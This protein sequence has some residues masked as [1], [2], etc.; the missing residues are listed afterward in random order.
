MAS[1]RG[2][3]SLRNL[4]TMRSQTLCSSQVEEMEKVRSHTAETHNKGDNC[5]I[6]LNSD[7]NVPD[8]DWEIP[9]L[10]PGCHH[11]D[12]CDRLIEITSEHHLEQIQREPTRLNNIL[13]LL[14]T[15][16]SVL[17]K[18]VSI[19]PGLSDHSTVLVDTYL[20][21][22]HNI[23]L[24][25]KSTNGHVLTGTRW[26]KRW[27]WVF[28]EQYFNTAPTQSVYQKSLRHLLSTLVSKHVP[29]KVS[30]SRRNISGWC[31]PYTEYAG[32]SRGHT[33]KPRRSAHHIAGGNFAH[34][35]DAPQQLLGQQEWTT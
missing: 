34:T 21:I 33:T 7:F 35:N 4:S 12:M 14:F 1:G 32:R 10:K 2:K 28:R 26:E 16:K 6:L 11:K 3:L 8:K 13:D 23:K 19:M 30:S 15:N 17:V 20:N 24:L 25:R 5:T 27:E 22:K 9:V 31:Y 18:E 29:Q